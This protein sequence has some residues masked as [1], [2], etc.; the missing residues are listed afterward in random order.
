MDLLNHGLKAKEAAMIDQQKGQFWYT[1][2]DTVEV[3]YDMFLIWHKNICSI[4]TDMSDPVKEWRSGV[5][6]PHHYNL[7][8]NIF[9]V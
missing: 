4:F 9:Q 1:G 5:K 3:M 6:S 2:I 7:E 8:N